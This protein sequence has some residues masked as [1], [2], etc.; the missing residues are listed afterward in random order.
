MWFGDKLPVYAIN[1]IEAYAKINGQFLINVICRKSSDLHEKTDDVF[2]EAAKK[3]LS[4]AKN[5][6]TQ[7]RFYEKIDYA[8]KNKMSDD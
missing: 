6:N 4:E 3:D 1:V 8:L 5:G 7:C 2:L